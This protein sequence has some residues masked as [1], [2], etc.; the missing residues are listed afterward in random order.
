[1]DDFA[2]A[3]RLHRLPQSIKV[4]N[5]R[6]EYFAGH[7]NDDEPKRELIQVELMLEFAIDGSRRRQIR[8]RQA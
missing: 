8:A 2:F 7:P 5:I 3:N 4:R 1:M 6:C